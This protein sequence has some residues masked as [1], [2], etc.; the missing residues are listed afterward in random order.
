MRFARKSKAVAEIVR[1]ADTAEARKEALDKLDSDFKEGDT[2][3]TFAKAQLQMQD[4]PR[5]ALATLESVT[6]PV[7]RGCSLCAEMTCRRRVLPQPGYSPDKRPLSDDPKLST[8]P[9]YA[10]STVGG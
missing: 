6:W 10:I 5:A 2:A 1:S 8:T 9:H 3:A 7:E 4:E